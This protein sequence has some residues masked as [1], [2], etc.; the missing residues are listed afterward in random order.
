[1]KMV[2]ARYKDQRLEDVPARKVEKGEVRVY[3]GRSGEVSH[4]H[5]SDWPMSLVDIR[6][7]AGGKLEQEVAPQDRG[8][9]YVLEGAG[10]IGGKAVKKG[11]VAWFEPGEGE[12]LPISASQ[13]LRTLLFA[14]EP[15]REPIFAYGP[16]VMT[17]R[18]EIVQAFNDYQAGRLVA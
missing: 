8:F 3:A 18:E 11:E 10:E 17:T 16:F 4:A 12:V 14:G 13:T 5:G 2:P 7:E 1:M 9:L 15:I 6:L